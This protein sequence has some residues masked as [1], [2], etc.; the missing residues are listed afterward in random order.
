[1]VTIHAVVINTLCIQYN[2]SSPFPSSS[3]A[4]ERYII[5]VENLALGKPAT[6]SDVLWSYKPGLAI[7]HI[8]NITLDAM[9]CN[10]KKYDAIRRSGG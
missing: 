10:A 3:K 8:W 9:P 2:T 7:L 4:F 1:M 5:A 6:Q